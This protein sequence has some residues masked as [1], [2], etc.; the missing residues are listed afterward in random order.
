MLRV[1]RHRVANAE[2]WVEDVKNMKVKQVY[3]QRRTKLDTRLYVA[4]LG[5]FIE[6]LAVRTNDE[7]FN[8][9]LYCLGR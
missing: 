3:M 7:G 5:E 2:I 1:A 8:L 9:S 6:S 4:L